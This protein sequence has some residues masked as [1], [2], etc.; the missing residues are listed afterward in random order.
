MR[1]VWKAFLNRLNSSV[2][3]SVDC[4]SFGVD[5]STKLDDELLEAKKIQFLGFSFVEHLNVEVP[6]EGLNLVFGSEEEE[7]IIL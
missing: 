3:I 6:D 7:F 2:G 1:K 4:V 5:K